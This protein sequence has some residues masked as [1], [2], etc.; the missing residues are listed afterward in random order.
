MCRDVQKKINNVEILIKQGNTSRETKTEG[1][2]LVYLNSQ[3]KEL[4]DEQSQCRLFSIRARMAIEAYK[5]A[6]AELNNNKL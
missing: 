4:A 2:D 1:A 6:I 5:T 3:Q